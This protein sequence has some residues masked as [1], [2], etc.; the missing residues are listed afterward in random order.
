MTTT[1]T[2][3]AIEIAGL[4]YS[5][6]DHR[7]VDG[8]DITVRRGEI[9]ALL[10]T[11][12]AGKTTTLELLEGT[13]RPAAGT[14]TVLGLD[15]VADRQ[16]LKPRLGVMLQNAG[17]IEDLT[18]AETL[19]LWAALSSRTDDVPDLLRRVDLAHRADVRVAALS[20]GERR[21]LDFALA[22]YGQPELVILDEPTTGL[23]PESRQRLWRTV[24]RLRDAGS[25]VLLT[26][27]YLE[28]A[29]SLADRVAI[30]HDGRISVAGTLTEVLAA[31]P[32]RITAVARH[33]HP[34]LPRLT[35]AVRATP[36]QDGTA[37]SVE[38]TELQRDLTTLLRWADDA[39]VPLHRLTANQ[40]SLSE[41]FL[42]ISE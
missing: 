2:D 38:T 29:E 36:D 20:G 42:A 32:A 17:L 12:G 33:P 19:R 13:R 5:Y 7:A 30:M 40:A 39:A 16:R 15:P 10:G 21:R 27:H 34:D 24:T 41:I 25:T 22:S 6:G 26:T 35:G 3:T 14:V 8:V 1:L 23:D 11:N 9:F 28:E 31:R 4:A 37:L 18:A